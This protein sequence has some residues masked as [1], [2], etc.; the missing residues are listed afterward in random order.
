[1]LQPCSNGPDRCGTKKIRRNCNGEMS[2]TFSW[3]NEDLCQT[4]QSRCYIT[5]IGTCEDC[6]QSSSYGIDESCITQDALHSWSSLRLLRCD[7]HPN[8][9]NEDLQGPPN[10]RRLLLAEKN[11]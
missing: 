5:S 1:V 10:R 6:T 9:N 7:K 8:C 2:E 3:C 4:S 11:L